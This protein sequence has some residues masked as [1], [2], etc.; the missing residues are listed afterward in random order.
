MPINTPHKKYTAVQDDYKTMRD[1]LEGERAVRA[2]IQRYLPPPPGLADNSG[3]PLNLNEI[4]SNNFSGNGGHNRYTFYAMF[5]E[6]VDIT[7][8]TISAI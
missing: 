1:W 2:D 3:A 7:N 6:F 8:T 5:A 4:V